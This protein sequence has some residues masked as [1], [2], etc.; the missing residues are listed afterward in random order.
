MLSVI[1]SLHTVKIMCACCDTQ[2]VSVS[3]WQ[4]FRVERG[5]QITYESGLFAEKK[6]S[7]LTM[8]IYID[9]LYSEYDRTMM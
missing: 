2:T 1:V 5:M 3:N 9:S 6:Y 4:T 7:L 8:E